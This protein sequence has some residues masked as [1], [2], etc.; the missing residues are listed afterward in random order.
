MSQIEEVIAGLE[1]ANINAAEKRELMQQIEQEGGVVSDELKQKLI[2]VFEN[3]ALEA[4][5]DTEASTELLT[6]MNDTP[7]GP[8]TEG[9][10]A[11]A[12]VAEIGREQEAEFAK[13]DDMVQAMKTDVTRMATDSLKTAEDSAESGNRLSVDQ[14]RESLRGESDANLTN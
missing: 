8:P 3:E 1:D 6:A 14:I 5:E 12:I 4:R 7:L 11:A 10:N 2:A 9:E 13:I